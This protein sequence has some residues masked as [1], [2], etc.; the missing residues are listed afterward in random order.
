MPD[1]S[2]M[3]PRFASSRKLAD[4]LDVSERHVRRQATGGDWPS[5][6]IGG[7]R[8]FDVAEIIGIVKTRTKAVWDSKGEECEE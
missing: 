4:F 5:Y 2:V 3:V 1:E 8:V 7:R 6:C